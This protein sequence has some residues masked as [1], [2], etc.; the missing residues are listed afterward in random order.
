MKNGKPKI[1]VFEVV[2][3]PM[4]SNLPDILSRTGEW[5]VWNDAEGKWERARNWSIN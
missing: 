4:K 3:G 2:K 5:W 1:I